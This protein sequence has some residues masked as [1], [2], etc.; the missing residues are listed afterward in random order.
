MELWNYWS[1]HPL[2]IVRIAS[3]AGPFWGW[4]WNGVWGVAGGWCCVGTLLGPEATHVVWV[5]VIS[6]RGGQ[7]VVVSVGVCGCVGVVWCLRIV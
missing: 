2:V 6:L 7:T 1:S 4:V 5:L 3:T